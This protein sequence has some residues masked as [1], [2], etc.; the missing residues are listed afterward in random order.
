MLNKLQKKNEI[1]LVFVSACYSE[2]LAKFI[3]EK[4]P[5]SIVIAIFNSMPVM[6]ESARIFASHFYEKLF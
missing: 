2:N 1:K 6:D 3:K 5:N 4:V